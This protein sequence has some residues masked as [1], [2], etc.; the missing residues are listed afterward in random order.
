MPVRVSPEI[1]RVGAVMKII[2][3]IRK[4]KKP[5]KDKRQA[6]GMVEFALVLPILLLLVF[7]I[8]EFGRLLFLFASVSSSSREGARYG[9]AVGDT[10]GGTLRYQDC[11]GIVAAA[12]RVGVLA[13]ITAADVIIQ[14]DDGSTVKFNSCADV[15][16][17]FGSPIILGDRIVV[18]VSRDFQPIVP[19]VNLPSFPISSTTARTIV[20]DVGVK[21]TP[22]PTPTKKPTMTPTD[23]PTSTPTDLPTKTKK[24]DPTMTASPTPSDTPEVVYTPTDVPT[25]IPPCELASAAVKSPLVGDE[26]GISSVYLRIQNSGAITL[27]LKSITFDWPPPIDDPSIQDQP[28]RLGEIRFDTN[29]G[30]GTSCDPGAGDP[31]ADPTTTCIWRGNPGSEPTT[32]LSLNSFDGN[33]DD[34]QM[35]PAAAKEMRFVFRTALKSSFSD[36][37]DPNPYPYNLSLSFGIAEDNACDI[38]IEGLNTYYLHHDD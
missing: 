5:S 1:T 12:S 29:T 31:P 24:K 2:K 18:T 9:A 28:L 22:L 37:Y 21:G 13:G 16:D 10:G 17:I 14:Y 35:V 15:Q 36:F 8:I 11:D 27:T 30:A 38:E 4:L 6:Q 33:P 7:G 32:H 25:A 3:T 19:L 34:I 26:N 20:R 23:L